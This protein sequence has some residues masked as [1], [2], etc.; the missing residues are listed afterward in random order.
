MSLLN[1]RAEKAE[2]VADPPPLSLHRYFQHD[3]TASATPQ[4]KQTSVVR[5]NCMDW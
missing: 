5:T 2:R 3:T 1:S 4:I